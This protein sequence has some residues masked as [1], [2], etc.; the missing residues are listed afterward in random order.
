MRRLRACSARHQAQLPSG[1]QLKDLEGHCVN[2]AWKESRL[3]WREPNFGRY[4]LALDTPPDRRGS[5]KLLHMIGNARATPTG[6]R[7]RSSSSRPNP[8]ST[9]ASTP[10]RGSTFHSAGPGRPSCSTSSWARERRSTCLIAGKTGSGKSTLLHALITNGALRY[11]P[12][13]LELYLIDFKKGVEFKVYATMELPHA[14]SSPSRANASS[15]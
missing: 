8:T 14:R 10:A 11:S 13:E 6:S 9:G 5:P 4:P 2:M 3:Q 1:F 15:A 7:C 12:D